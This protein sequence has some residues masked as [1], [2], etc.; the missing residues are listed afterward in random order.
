MLDSG[1]EDETKHGGDGEGAGEKILAGDP[2]RNQ[3][4][5]VPK[6]GII[7]IE[8]QF[9]VERKGDTPSLRRDKEAQRQK[10][11]Q[12]DKHFEKEMSKVEEAC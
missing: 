6:D 7:H 8:N 2:M 3:Q 10:G 12:H 11:K 4:C 5:K 9:T 1:G